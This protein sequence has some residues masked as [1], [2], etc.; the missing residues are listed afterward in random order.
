MEETAFQVHVPWQIYNYDEHVEMGLGTSTTYMKGNYALV[1][2]L[3]GPLSM[4]VGNDALLGYAP[5][6]VVGDYESKTYVSYLA[7]DNAQTKTTVAGA[8]GA[9]T[10]PL[11][12]GVVQTDAQAY[13]DD[14]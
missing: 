13:D 9:I 3:H 11:V 8:L 1:M 14:N 10:S 4:Q 5:S 12:G 6:Q 2:S 7:G